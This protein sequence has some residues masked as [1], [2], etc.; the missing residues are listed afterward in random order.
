METMA[1]VCKKLDNRLTFPNRFPT[2]RCWVRVGELD[3]NS[4]EHPALT[5]KETSSR[6]AELARREKEH[7]STSSDTEKALEPKKRVLNK[8]SY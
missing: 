6:G 7:G 2:V 3:K 8:L 5:T 4:T 1:Q